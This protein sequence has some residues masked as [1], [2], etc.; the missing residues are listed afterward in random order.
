MNYASG[1]GLSHSPYKGGADDRDSAPGPGEPAIVGHEFWEQ[2]F[3]QNL[4]NK[5]RSATCLEAK[6]TNRNHDIGRHHTVGLVG[7]RMEAFPT[8]TAG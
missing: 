4:T 8:T 2:A 6:V 5:R 3:R 1:M 7:R